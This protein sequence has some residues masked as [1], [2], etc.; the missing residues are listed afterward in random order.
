MEILDRIQIEPKSWIDFAALTSPTNSGFTTE[1]V[2]LRG[3]RVDIC[4]FTNLF[5]SRLCPIQAAHCGIHV[6]FNSTPTLGLLMFVI[7]RAFLRAAK[8]AFVLVTLVGTPFA[9]KLCRYKFHTN[10]TRCLDTVK[11]I[12]IKV[13]QM[14]KNVEF[15]V[16]K[17]KHF[18]FFISDNWN[19]LNDKHVSE[20][21]TSG[22]HRGHL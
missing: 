16:K 6:S 5:V 11:S 7:S 13:H 19:I 8:F 1:M 15:K 12:G 14:E 9:L 17:W 4:A 10:T 22:S 20:R 21:R 2:R 3:L 18:F